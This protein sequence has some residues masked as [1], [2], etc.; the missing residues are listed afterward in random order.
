MVGTKG[1]IATDDDNY[2][3]SMTEL[4]GDEPLK[5]MPTDD[6]ASSI[7]LVLEKNGK[8]AGIPADEKRRKETLAVF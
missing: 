3:F 6:P 5:G 8:R 7:R 4:T 2:R 1:K